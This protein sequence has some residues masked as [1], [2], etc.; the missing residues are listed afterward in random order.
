MDQRVSM[1]Y[2]CVLLRLLEELRGFCDEV[3][4]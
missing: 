1:Y 2:R 4:V 3:D